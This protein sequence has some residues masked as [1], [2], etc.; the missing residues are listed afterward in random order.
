MFSE[1]TAMIKWEK[2]NKKLWVP[3]VGA[4]DAPAG[5][6]E[7]PQIGHGGDGAANRASH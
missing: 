6:D 5:P 4:T 1:Y 7:A 3:F 2:K